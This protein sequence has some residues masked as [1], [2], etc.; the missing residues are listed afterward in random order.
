[1][2]ATILPQSCLNEWFVPF[3]HNAVEGLAEVV[4]AVPCARRLVARQIRCTKP[5][6]HSSGSAAKRRTLNGYDAVG[7]L[8]LADIYLNCCIGMH[9]YQTDHIVIQFDSSS[10]IL[11]HFESFFINV[12]SLFIEF[13]TF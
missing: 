4:N 7:K 5:I 12:Y 10:L 1:M 8:C 3:R 2:L 9:G 13:N 6:A 11:N